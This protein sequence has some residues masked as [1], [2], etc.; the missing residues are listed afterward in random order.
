M[1]WQTI[2]GETV[3]LDV[4]GRQLMGLNEVGA[5]I[6]SLCDGEHSAAEIAAAVARDFAVDEATARADVDAFLSELTRLGALA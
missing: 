1:A 6:W 5:L 2:A 3:L 4:D